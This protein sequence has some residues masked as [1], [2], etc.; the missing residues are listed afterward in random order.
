MR[1]RKV[2]AGVL[3][4]LVLVTGLGVTS[5]AAAA[6][7]QA[8]FW[9][10]KEPAKAS[11]ANEHRFYLAVKSHAMDIS[12]RYNRMGMTSN[13]LKE[14]TLDTGYDICRGLNEGMTAKDFRDFARDEG[15][16]GALFSYTMRVNYEATRYLC[17]EHEDVFDTWWKK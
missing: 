3:G 17:P 2:A 9:D 10:N 16:T 8:W 13:Q 1:L 7:A 6:P 14:L 15:A 11:W 4:A 5:V 12:G